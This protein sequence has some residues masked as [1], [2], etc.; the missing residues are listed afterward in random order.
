MD[1]LLELFGL[2]AGA[3]TSFGFIPQLIKGHR[4][5]KLND[6]SYYMPIVLSVGM[7]LWFT[8]GI[9]IDSLAVIISNAFGVG[10]CITLL[11]MKILYDI[12]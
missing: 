6:V 8:Y 4:T 10:C 9:L 12:S 2:I 11:L 1:T 5:K 7:S 3:I